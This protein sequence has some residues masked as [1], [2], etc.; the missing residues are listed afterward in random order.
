MGICLPIALLS[1][2]VAADRGADG[3]EPLPGNPR[4]VSSPRELLELAGI[5]PDQFERLTDGVAWQA[6]EDEVLLKILFRLGRFRLAEIEGWA[7]DDPEPAELAED[8]SARRGE[9]FRLRGRVVRAEVVRLPADE[10]ERFELN[11]YYRCELVLEQKAAPA[12]VFARTLPRAGTTGGPVDA[13]SG[14]LGMFL[15]AGRDDQRRWRPV[16]AARRIAWYPPT[17]LGELGMDVGLF[18]DL[19]GA[20]PE[21]RRARS[22]ASRSPVCRQQAGGGARNRCG[23]DPGN[24]FTRGAGGRAGP[25]RGS[26]SPQ[27]KTSCDGRAPRVS[28]SCPCSMSP[29]VNRGVWYS[30]RARRGR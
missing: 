24:S 28:P 15:K 23:A 1:L 9:M 16:F 18:D 17:R 26:C 3:L 19:R 25:R 21:D 10:A 7:R 6:T 30:C 20:E 12:I 8:P 22:P 27:P 2:V 4:T 14:A 29:C 5:G 13:R 11:E